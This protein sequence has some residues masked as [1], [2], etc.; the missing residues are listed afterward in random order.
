MGVKVVKGSETHSI[1]A[2]IIISTAG[3]YN[4]FLRLLPEAVASKSYFYKIAK[5]MKP[6]SA[7]MSIFVGLV[8]SSDIKYLNFNPRNDSCFSHVL[9]VTKE[10]T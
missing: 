8:N 5:D 3:V 4:T 10:R 6:A 1:Y 7:A 9:N 2:P